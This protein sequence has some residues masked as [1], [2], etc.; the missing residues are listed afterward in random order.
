MHALVAP[1]FVRVDDRFRVAARPVHVAGGFELAT[2]LGVVVDLA[3]ERDPDAAV[4]VR[5]RLMATGEIDDAQAPMAEHG[6]LV[7]LKACAVRATVADH[8]THPDD[9]LAIIGVKTFGGDNAGNPAHVR[10]LSPWRTRAADRQHR[11][12]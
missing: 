3:V 10:Q 5:E 2:D 6:A 12:R 9:A 1:L 8:G 4:L 11:R 7:G